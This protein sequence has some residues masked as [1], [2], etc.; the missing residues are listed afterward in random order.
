[1][2]GEQYVSISYIKP[3]LHLFNQ[4]V[5]KPADDDTDLNK[6]I[7][8]TVTTYLNPKYDDT[9]THDLLN[10]ASPVNPHFKTRYIQDEKLETVK[11]TVVVQM[12]SGNCL[13]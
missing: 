2:T 3:I 8:N 10:I 9:A 7:K 5:L 11:S 6:H 13:S 1:M 12:L 4:E